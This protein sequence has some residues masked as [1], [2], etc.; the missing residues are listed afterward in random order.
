MRAC[1]CPAPWPLLAGQ[2]SPDGRILATGCDDPRHDEES[3]CL[4]DTSGPLARPP[5][6]I[7]RL[8]GLRLRAWYDDG[9]LLAARLGDPNKERQPKKPDQESVRETVL[10]DLQGRVRQVLARDAAWIPGPG[11]TG[12]FSPIPP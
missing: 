12:N 4:G 6:R 5:G 10:A 11:A 7:R 9:H 3:I 8:A 1:H 2:F